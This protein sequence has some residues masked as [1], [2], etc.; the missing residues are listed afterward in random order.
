MKTFD[1]VVKD[2][3]KLEDYGFIYNAG[4]QYSRGDYRFYSKTRPVPQLIVDPNRKTISL[5][6]PSTIAVKTLCEMYSAGLI[7]FVDYRTQPKY[8]LGL[9][10]EEYEMIIKMRKEK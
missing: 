8:N 4:S 10:K 2:L 3:S 5:N 6:S 7:E 1:I 9:T